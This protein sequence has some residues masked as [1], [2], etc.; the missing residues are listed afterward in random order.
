MISLHVEWLLS[1]WYSVAMT[2]DDLFMQNTNLCF[3]KLPIGNWKKYFQKCPLDLSSL[4]K[5]MVMSYSALQCS[6][7]N[8]SLRHGGIDGKLRQIFSTYFKG[9]EI[10]HCEFTV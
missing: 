5:V 9:F 2:L 1:H 8:D 3:L 7:L 4:A 10:L 6:A